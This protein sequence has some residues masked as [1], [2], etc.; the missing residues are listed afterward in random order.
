MNPTILPT[1]VTTQAA[2]DYQRVEKAI[3]FLT[4]HAPEQP[5]LSPV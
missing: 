1:N 3:A 2:L 4:A 5:A